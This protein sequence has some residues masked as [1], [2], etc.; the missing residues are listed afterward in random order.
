MGLKYCLEVVSKEAL[1]G[2]KKDSFPLLTLF[3][4]F[5]VPLWLEYFLNDMAMHIGQTAVDA[6]MTYCQLGVVD[7]E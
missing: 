1:I 3:L 2:N 5:S 6:I 4:L 7:A